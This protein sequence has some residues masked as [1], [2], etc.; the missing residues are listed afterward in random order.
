VIAA[1]GAGNPPPRPRPPEEVQR[2]ALQAVLRRGDL[3]LDP[4]RLWLAY[5]ALGGTTG[6]VEVDGYLHGVVDLPELDRDL[7][8]LAANTR[9]DEVAGAQRVPYTRPVRHPCPSQ[10]PL[11]AL[12]T[13]LRQIPKA[14]GGDV[15]AAAAAA[16]Q[17]L[18]VRTRVYLVDYQQRHLVPLTGAGEEEGAPLAVDGTLA[19]RAFRTGSTQVALSD[20]EPRLWVPV[21][22][23][24]ERLGVLDVVLEARSELHDP[25]LREQCEWLGRLLG[26]LV[27]AADQHGD[28]VHQARSTRARS[29]AAELVWRLLPPLTTGGERFTLSGLL[30][31]AYDVGGDVFD[32][33]LSQTRV[34]L[35]VVDAMGHALEAGLIATAALAAYRT[36]RRA[37]RSLYD[38][39]AAVD[40]VL[41]VHF[42][43]ALATGV[44]ATLD[45]DSGR[46]RY[47][48]AGHPAPLLLREGRVVT[49][50]DEGRRTPFG[51]TT[52]ALTIGEVVLQPGDAL[53]LYTDGVVEAR[54]EQGRFFGLE[55]LVD[56]LERAAAAEQPPP[57]TVRRLI[58]AVLDHQ[59]GVLQ[60]DATVLIAS[61]GT[62]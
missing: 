16:G 22:D 55:R 17:R 33:A 54:D 41:A 40:E 15:P 34:D 2:R 1:A 24:A 46:L 21:L 44:L 43:D 12:V 57:E 51:L 30:E 39:A 37:G 61:W 60:D 49:T 50:L 28:A 18:G 59:H 32:Y 36:A 25:W 45:L 8:A 38:Q 52:G 19:G 3:G 29:P 23:S 58:G 4:E 14:V 35:A 20:P 11:A 13:L 56:L 10:G 31:P 7:L 47:L 27:V 42:P 6:L 9:L 62:R 26:H 48:A 53:V 5:F